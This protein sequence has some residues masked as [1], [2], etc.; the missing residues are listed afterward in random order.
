MVDNPQKKEYQNQ[1]KNLKI[2]YHFIKGCCFFVVGLLPIAYQLPRNSELK[3][4]KS[5][6]I[7]KY[8]KK[9]LFIKHFV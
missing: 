2:E 5:S 4:Q 8:E 9:I 3:N 7:E 6:E 1:K